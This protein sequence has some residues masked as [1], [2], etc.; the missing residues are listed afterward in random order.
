MIEDDDLLSFLSHFGQSQ[1][2]G[3]VP[4]RN[5][6]PTKYFVNVFDQALMMIVFKSV[7]MVHVQKDNLQFC[8]EK[9]GK[10]SVQ[11]FINYLVFSFKIIFFY[12]TNVL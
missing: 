5:E 11:I 4:H 12:F 2:S 10:R 9:G 7:K 6:F 3:V 8:K 1:T